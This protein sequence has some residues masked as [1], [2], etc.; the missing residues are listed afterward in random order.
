MKRILTILSLAMVALGA[1]AQEYNQVPAAWKWL[2][3]T[4]VAF[5]MNRSFT[6]ETCYSLDAVTLKKKEGVKAPAKF[7]S[8]PVRPQGAVNVTLS[9]DSSKVA[10]TRNNNLF[11]LDI[12]SGVEKQ[13]TFDGSDLILNGYA[14]WV[15]YEEIL[16]RSSQ[17]KAFWWSPDSKKIAYYKFDNS[18]VPMFPI[19]SPVGQDGKL[20][21]TR[22]PKAGE[23]N[24]EVKI[25]FVDITNAFEP[26]WGPNTVW[27]HFNEKD[28]QYFGIPFWGDDSKRFFVARE[29][30]IQNTLDLYSVE[31]ATGI[32]TAIY[33][34]EYKTWIDWPEEMLFT[35][36]GLYM[37]RAF[38]TGWEQIYFLSY[39]GKE[40][41]RITDGEN[42]RTRLIRV[43]DKNIYFT[44]ERG[45]VAKSALY[46]TSLK[47]ARGSQYGKTEALTDPAYAVSSV[48]F[49]PDGK[50][51]VAAV[52][53]LSTP[54]QIWLHGKKTTLV[55]DSKGP[56]FD[57]SKYAMPELVQ[58]KAN[59]GQMLTAK[60]TLPKNFDPS[61]KYPVHFEIYGGPNTAY[62]SDRW[63]NP[64]GSQWWSDN[65][66]IAVT[67]DSRAAGHT[68]RAGTDLV[69][70]DLT[71]VPTEDFVTWGKY[72]QSLPYVQADKIGVEGFSFGGTMTSM[73][74]LEHS[75]VFHYGIAG[76]GVY[77]WKLYDSHYTERFMETPQTNPDGY[78][79]ARVLSH[80]KNFPVA[81]GKGDGSIVLKI[82]HGTGDD[83]VHFQ[84]T[85]QLI[86]EMQKEGKEFELMIY[87]DGMHGYRGYQG[88]HSSAADRGFWLKHLL[89]K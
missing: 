58:I 85:L 27:A 7:S 18:K 11:V 17:Y 78:E 60:V 8:I 74:L 55:A 57:A 53:N 82:T 49:S 75:D 28:D 26:N 48:S 37:V 39:D 66:I 1:A 6:D 63:S 30:R 47:P 25:G 59:D 80:V 56:D 62:V 34:E 87:P 14:S 33:H 43:D 9:P 81:S 10:F 4:E 71:S 86:D 77:D 3:N 65:G 42:W 12:E 24:P 67:A 32:K 20:S 84:N 21:Q 61:K 70:C 64:A 19:Y 73:L 52:S 2:S 50:Y 23:M 15:Y 36:K 54:T 88:Q 5:S 16:G 13:L 41:R 51:F 68:G 69:Y 45:A 40:L 83:N 38:E 79:S 22:Y 76:G 89:G 72:F 46:R 35:D 29:P 44:S 31:A